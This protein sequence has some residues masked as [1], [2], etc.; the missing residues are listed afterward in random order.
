MLNTYSFGGEND[1]IKNCYLSKL[2]MEMR[3]NGQTVNNIKIIK[4][5]NK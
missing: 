4:I 3:L 2:G 1:W 5:N